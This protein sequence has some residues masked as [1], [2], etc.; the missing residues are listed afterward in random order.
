[1]VYWRSRFPGRPWL[2]ALAVGLV[3]AAGCSG[4]S[5]S[6][7]EPTSTASPSST[8]TATTTD[9]GPDGFV[10]A[11]APNPSQPG[12]EPDSVRLVDFTGG[13]HRDIGDPGMFVDIAFSPDGVFLATADV[14]GDT[15]VYEVATGHEAFSVSASAAVTDLSWSPTSGALAIVRADS[16]A[17]IEVTG[18]A[19]AVPGI[20]AAADANPLRWG[21][22]PDGEV[23]A[24]VTEEALVLQPLAAGADLVRLP[25]AEFPAVSDQWVVRTGTVDGEIGLVDL[26]PVSG[27]P[28]GRAEYAYTLDA[29][30]TLVVG[31]LRFVSI[32][33]WGTLPS[34]A[35]DV[36]TAREFPTVRK[37]CDPCRSADGASSVIVLWIAGTSPTPTPDVTAWPPTTD[38]VLA[39][40]GLDGRATA[41]G[42]GIKPEGEISVSD[43]VPVYDVVRPAN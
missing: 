5:E 39:V 43:W 28:E 18:R 23:F 21:W 24:L 41:V 29:G 19:T 38:T 34:P 12:V 20:G 6:R 27:L 8:G 9:Q 15:R 14:E 1:M 35:F 7:V 42:L 17:F 36:A 26:T 25:S 40:E 4:G 2:A 10:I 37:T 30:G 16:V 3:F 33:D 13:E 11:F 31:E 22:T 32:Y